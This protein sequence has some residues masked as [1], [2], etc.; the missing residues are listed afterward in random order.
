MQAQEILI[1]VSIGLYYPPFHHLTG[2]P[3]LFLSMLV[4]IFSLNSYFSGVSNDVPCWQ[5]EDKGY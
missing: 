4:P 3:H 2:F 5:A 1:R